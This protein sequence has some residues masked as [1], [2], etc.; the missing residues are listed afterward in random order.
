MDGIVAIPHLGAS[1]EEAEDNCAVMAAQQL[2][3]YIENGNITN[4]VNLPNIKVPKSATHRYTVISTDNGT[5]RFGGVSATRNGLRY[6]VIDSDDD[7]TF[8]GNDIIKA[9]KV[10]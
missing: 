9:R 6:T 8:E 10:Y 4:S 2:K 5:N 7:L 3:D 1:T